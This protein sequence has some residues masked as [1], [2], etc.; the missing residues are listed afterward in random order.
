MCNCTCIGAGL[1]VAPA[2][3]QV[4][5]ENTK[6]IVTIKHEPQIG[7]T[8]QRALDAWLTPNPHFLRQ[9]PLLHP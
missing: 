3:A 1:S 4:R 8:P 5:P 6:N 9:E 2:S 7:E